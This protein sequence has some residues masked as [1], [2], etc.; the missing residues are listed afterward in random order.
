MCWFTFLFKSAVPLSSQHNP[1]SRPRESISY[2][3]FAVALEISQRQMKDM[4]LFQFSFLEDFEENPRFLE[5]AG[6]EGSR[7][8]IDGI[9]RRAGVVKERLNGCCRCLL[10]ARKV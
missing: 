5:K 8:D 10:E 4:S 7:I 6:S 3:T 2:Q 1:S 9:N